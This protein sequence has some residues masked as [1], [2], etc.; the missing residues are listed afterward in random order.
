MQPRPPGPFPQVSSH[1]AGRDAWRLYGRG[2]GA[3][4]VAALERIACR[5]LKPNVTLL[6]DID[7]ETGLARARQASNASTTF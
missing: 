3:D 7:P 2:L 6:V 5:G 1:S 4:A